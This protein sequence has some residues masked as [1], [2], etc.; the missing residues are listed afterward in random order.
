MATFLICGQHYFT[1]C[2]FV[3]TFDNVAT[4]SMTNKNKNAAT[5]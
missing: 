1:K 3:I 4:P 2:N 5:L